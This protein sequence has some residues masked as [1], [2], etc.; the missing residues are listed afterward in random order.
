MARSIPKLQYAIKLHE[1]SKML[2]KQK[3][4]GWQQSKIT[5]AQTMGSVIVMDYDMQF[6]EQTEVKQSQITKKTNKLINK[7]I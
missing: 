2:V 6:G 3:L 4:E 7:K 5:K 1:M